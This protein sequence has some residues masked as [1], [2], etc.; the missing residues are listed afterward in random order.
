MLE[1]SS[2]ACSQSPEQLRLKQFMVMDCGIWNKNPSMGFK[3]LV[4]RK[5]KFSY[6]VEADRSCDLADYIS[7]R[8][9][10]CDWEGPTEPM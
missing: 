8:M 10:P 2:V 4:S 9:G 5:L 6:I 7:Y 3:F 1:G